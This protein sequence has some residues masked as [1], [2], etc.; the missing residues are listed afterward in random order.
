MQRHRQEAV[1]KTR[2]VLGALCVAGFALFFV[3]NARAELSGA[4][5]AFG[6]DWGFDRA[7][8]HYAEM[9][10]QGGAKLN[11]ICAFD[12]GVLFNNNRFF[13]ERV[14]FVGAAVS[15]SKTPGALLSRFAVGL[16]YVYD[17]IPR[18]EVR[19]HSFI[20]SVSFKS[21]H[22]GVTL[23]PHWRWTNFFG[24]ATILE[25]QLALSLTVTPFSGERWRAG[26]AIANFDEYFP[27][28]FWDFYLNVFFAYRFNERLSL[29]TSFY[30]YQTGLDGWTVLFY[31]C[32]VRSALKLSW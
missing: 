17:D 15:L 30:A 26:F 8:R 16:L 28:G 12:A 23:G 27:G 25:G 7:T 31:G 13:E 18:Y 20:P 24:E 3:A 1:V 2:R 19:S 22:F 9:F 6:F 5:G 29:D 10:V 11:G 32:K 21:K 4:R 14:S